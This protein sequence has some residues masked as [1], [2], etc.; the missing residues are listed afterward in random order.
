MIYLF[1][2]VDE[3]FVLLDFFKFSDPLWISTTTYHQPRMVQCPTV[4]IVRR[5]T[6]VY[7]NHEGRSHWTRYCLLT[8]KIYLFLTLYH[9]VEMH[10]NGQSHFCKEN[11][12]WIFCDNF[13]FEKLHSLITR[14]F[15]I[16]SKKIAI[17]YVF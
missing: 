11:S 2:L 13:F 17:Y 10:L 5:C 4:Y 9:N 1:F 6:F 14:I 16:G 12:E 3:F 7:E 15:C 8:L